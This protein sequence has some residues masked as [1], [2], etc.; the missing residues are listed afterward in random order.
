MKNRPVHSQTGS[1]LLVSILLLLLL[2]IIT[3]FAVRVGLS[4]QRGATSDA[5]AKTVHQV[6]QA[7][8]DQAVE[9]VR[10]NRATL[11]PAPGVQPASAQWTA[12]LSNDR[13]FPC[14]AIEPGKATS[15][16]RA[17][18]FA[19]T[20]GAD[21]GRAAS[22]PDV[23]ERS[24]PM[25]QNFT[26]VGNFP[27][28][29]NVGAV[30]CLI[31]AST[32]GPGKSSTCTIDGTKSNTV[33]V[34]LVSTG[35]IDGETARSTI[36]EALGQYRIINV[37]P[38]LPPVVA[39]S[40]IE[41]LGNGT[42]VSNPDGGGKGVPLAVWTRST[43]GAVGDT[44][45]GSFQTCQT[46]EY[47]HN[48]SNST[49]ASNGAITCTNCSCAAI[50]K[51]SEN[52][53]EGKDM[54]DRDDTD[55]GTNK[56][57]DTV[58]SPTYSFPCDLFAYVFGV[59]TRRNDPAAVTADPYSDVP[60][61]C[62]TQV[63][64]DGNGTADVNQFLQN[65]D[66]FTTV[67]DCDT[68]VG[69]NTGGFFYMPNGCALS[70]PGSIGTPT[71]PV[72]MVVDRSFKNSGPTIYGLIFVR[73]PA[74]VYA[75]S[76]AAEYAPGGGTATIYGALVIEGP[77]KLNGGLDIISSPAIL[78]TIGNDPK[79]VKFARVPGTWNDTLSY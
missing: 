55:P 31:D 22:D 29:Y 17:R 56:A 35:Q 16:L 25:G 13:R 38:G 40:I 18:Y 42:I 5:R 26:S 49:V 76:G 72:V 20:G 77:G 19:F 37:P 47:F 9:Y 51:I 41:G 27:V 43:L 15:T 10:L 60:P 28:T 12:C 36:S 44:S 58:I 24:L 59:Q 65:T 52:G 45:S 62:E 73:D 54:L 79:N 61:L 74:P 39:S 57:V 64:A 46:D 7:G 6:A 78:N 48:G 14:G 50:D 68:L 32:V 67:A 1:A 63:D 53:T 70:G 66:N 71:K 23:D 3:F 2:S 34:T 75:T 4:E 33:S 8:L 11:L 21:D 30:L 69:N